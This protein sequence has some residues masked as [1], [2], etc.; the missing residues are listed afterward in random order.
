MKIAIV[1]AGC[2]LVWMVSARKHLHD[3]YVTYPR[4]IPLKSCKK[5][6]NYGI[7]PVCR[8]TCRYGACSAETRKEKPGKKKWRVFPKKNR[9]L[10]SFCCRCCCDKQGFAHCNDG[11]LST[12]SYYC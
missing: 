9:A 11:Y 5:E 8:V 3:G 4:F 10:G 12:L 1:L 6:T 2:V 7:S